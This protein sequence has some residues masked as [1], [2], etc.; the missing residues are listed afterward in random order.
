[1]AAIAEIVQKTNDF[2]LVTAHSNAACDELAT[3]LLDV[4]HNGQLYRLYA[5]SVSIDQVRPELKPV[6]NLW[7]NKF[8]F[9]ALEYLYQYRVI[10]S[11]L[12]TTGTLVR[13]RG[14]DPDFDSSHF[15]RLFIDEAACVHE[16]ASMIPI[17]GLNFLL[18]ILPYS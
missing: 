17:A 11:T 3:R 9:P 18:W 6:C 16:P 13:S 8:E 5:K 1:M 14:E 2:I 10:V 7:N 12:S 4:L 15:S